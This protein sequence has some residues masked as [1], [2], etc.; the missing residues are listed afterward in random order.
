MFITMPVIAM[1][2]DAFTQD[3]MTF[4]LDRGHVETMAF[5]EGPHRCPGAAAAL[6][7][8]SALTLKLAELHFS[9]NDP[10]TPD[11]Y[12]RFIIAMAGLNFLLLKIETSA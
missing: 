5:S 6:S 7:W 1:H 8:L 4:N 2:L 12:T 9:R 11:Y 3:H 10:T